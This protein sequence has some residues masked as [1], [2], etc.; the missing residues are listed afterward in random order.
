MLLRVQQALRGYSALLR[1]RPVATNATQGALL[2]ALGDVAAQRIEAR[3][4]IDEGSEQ[5]F[6]ITLPAHQDQQEYQPAPSLDYVRSARAALIGS[7]WS[8]YLY[9][10]VYRRLD[11]AFPGVAAR[12]VVS[13]AVADIALFGVVGNAASLLL[14]GSATSEVWQKM[15]DVLVNELRVWLPYNLFAFRVVPVHVRPTTTACLSLGWHTYIS[16]T[17]AA[18]AED[19]ER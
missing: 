19:E 14:R 15:P 16:Y 6:Q 11:A 4:R 2:A 1:E 10:T 5:R 7:F 12:E 8:A 3:S 17:A 9:P 13:K 18:K